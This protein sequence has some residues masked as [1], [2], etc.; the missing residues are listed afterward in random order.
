MRAVSSVN[1]PQGIVAAAK[2]TLPE[3]DRLKP[4]V[5]ADGI[6]ALIRRERTN[7][8]DMGIGYRSNYHCI[9]YSFINAAARINGMSYSTLMHGLKVAGID[10]NRKILADLAVNDA[11]AFAALC[12]QAKAKLA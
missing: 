5:I 11:A 9:A 1:T 8:S 12:E 2:F 7:I 3:A 6:T 10:L 4:A